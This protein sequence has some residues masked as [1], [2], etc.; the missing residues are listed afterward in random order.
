M[1]AR[2]IIPY[3]DWDEFLQKNEYDLAASFKNMGRFRVNIYRQR[4]SISIA[5]RPIRDGVPTFEELNLPAWLKDFAFK[6]QGLILVSDFAY[7]FG[8][9][10][11]QNRTSTI[12]MTK[13]DLKRR[14]KGKIIKLPSIDG[15]HW[16]TVYQP[17]IWER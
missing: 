9:D 16:D 6:P 17:S 7:V 12:R 5:M 8:S 14:R 10:G 15:I 2:E 11:Y 13:V 1:Y 3:S 4:N